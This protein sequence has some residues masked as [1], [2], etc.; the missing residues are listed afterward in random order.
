MRDATFGDGADTR[1]SSWPDI[2]DA[3][4]AAIISDST[5][6]SPQQDAADTGTD[7]DFDDAPTDI[8]QPGDSWCDGDRLMSCNASGLAEVEQDCSGLSN[9]CEVG[10][11][12]E[13]ENRC[14]GQP[15]SSGTRWCDGNILMACDGQGSSEVVKDCASDSDRCN[16]GVC[17]STNRR[18]E[19]EPLS[20]DVSWCEGDVLYTC[21]SSGASVVSQNCADLSDA[22]NT[23][24][25]DSAEN[26]C[27]AVPL[28]VNSVCLGNGVCDDSG[29]CLCTPDD[30]WCYEN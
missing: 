7:S 11:C 19:L 12:N 29:T 17:N 1:D 9:T 21:N 27:A 2:M 3:A 28:P 15:R 16:T 30:S 18:C 22:C 23:G 25:C 8:C 13:S 4:E 26:R 5:I 20:S 14:E 24:E 6:D 10:R